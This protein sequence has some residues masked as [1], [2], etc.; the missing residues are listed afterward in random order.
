M[1]P[2]NAWSQDGTLGFFAWNNPDLYIPVRRETH[3]YTFFFKADGERVEMEAIGPCLDL[4]QA[5]YEQQQ[6]EVTGK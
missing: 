6:R 1:A 4:L 5:T 3:G 2:F